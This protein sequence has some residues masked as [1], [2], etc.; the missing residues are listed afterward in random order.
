MFAGSRTF[1]PGARAGLATATAR[2]LITALSSLRIRTRQT[3]R[4]A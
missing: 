3:T 2:L 1:L 4:P